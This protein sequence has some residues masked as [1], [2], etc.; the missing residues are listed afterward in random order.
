[1]KMEHTEKVQNCRKYEEGA[2]SYEE[3]CWFIHVNVKNI[4]NNKQNEYNDT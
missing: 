3:K 1:M 2:C 4:E